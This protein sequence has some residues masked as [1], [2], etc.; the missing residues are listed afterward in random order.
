MKGGPMRSPN[1]Y[2]AATLRVAGAQM[3]MGQPMPM[4]QD[5]AF[6]ADFL[7]G[8]LVADNELRRR[9]AVFQKTGEVFAGDD[10]E[11]VL[12]SQWFGADFKHRRH[13]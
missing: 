12:G 11:P 10:T 7:L 6:G 8:R 13:P 2:V 9:A 5:R 4:R 3:G 1:D